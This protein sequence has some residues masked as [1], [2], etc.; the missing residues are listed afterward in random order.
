MHPWP[1]SRSSCARSSAGANTCAASY[2]TQLP[3]YLER[4]TLGADEDLPH[5]YWTGATDMA[6]LR[7]AIEQTLTHGY[8]NPIQRLMVTGLNALMLGVQPKQ[9]HA[10]YLAARSASTAWFPMAEPFPPTLPAAQARIAAV[11]AGGLCAHGPSSM[12]RIWKP[13]PGLACRP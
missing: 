8:A 12:R 10:W 2:W 6:C 11:R 3:G 4:N 7:D 1:A 13:A 5:W 9:V